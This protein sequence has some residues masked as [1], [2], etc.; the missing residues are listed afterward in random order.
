MKDDLEP[1]IIGDVIEV[2]PV[3]DAHP[4]GPVWWRA[5][6]IGKARKAWLELRKRIERQT[7]SVL[8]YALLDAHKYTAMEKEI[9]GGNGQWFDAEG[10]IAV[11][12]AVANALLAA[13]GDCA[14]EGDLAKRLAM[15]AA[16]I[17][18]G[19][20]PAQGGPLLVRFKDKPDWI[21]IESAIFEVTKRLA[22]ENASRGI[23]T[24]PTQKD[25]Q[26]AIEASCGFRRGRARMERPGS[27]KWDDAFVA[28]G[29]GSLPTGRERSR[30]K[31]TFRT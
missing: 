19:C 20:P 3:K 17:E 31:G 29:L 8:A 21:L 13:I 12:Q 10:R 27:T 2:V 18:T 25:I 16:E 11:R 4:L 1:V 9:A 22:R 7:A 23:F 6:M 30:G 28:C 14:D 24:T 15:A 26:D 5:R